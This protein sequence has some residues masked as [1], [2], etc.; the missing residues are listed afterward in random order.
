MTITQ[1]PNRPQA[2]W[3]AWNAKE[4][5]N[6]ACP[7]KNHLTSISYDLLCCSLHTASLLSPHKF[8]ISRL[9]S[10]ARC[11]S[12]SLACGLPRRNDVTGPN[13]AGCR[14]QRLPGPD[15]RQCDLVG[16]TAAEIHRQELTVHNERSDWE[17]AHSQ[18]TANRGHRAIQDHRD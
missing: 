13:R 10:I 11:L 17:L 15:R 16:P 5:I 2:Q 14:R 3:N 8:D 4:A 1:I 9:S 6:I 18:P 7:I 12:P